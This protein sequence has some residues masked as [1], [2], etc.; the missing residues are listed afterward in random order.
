MNKYIDFLQS[1]S[2]RAY[3]Y[4]TKSIVKTEQQKQLERLVM[5]KEDASQLLNVADI[6][7]G[8]GT[9]TYH[10]KKLYPYSRLFLVDLNPEALL[11]ARAINQDARIHLLRGDCYNLALKDNSF[12]LVCC[13]QTL[14]W[15]DDA[16][17]ALHEMIRVIKPGRRIYLSSLFNI[18]CDVDIYSR[19][20]DHTWEQGGEAV[21]VNYNT[22]SS[23]SISRWLDGLVSSFELIPF[24]PEIDF[25][26]DGRGLGTYTRK[27][28]GGR[29]QVSGGMLLNWAILII[30]K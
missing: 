26:Y 23:Y 9:L 17:E 10:L 24:E 11:I 28:E 21:P 3:D 1:D 15:L 14:S 12:D 4:Y 29:I 5:E 30:E 27:C 16:Q 13:W 20:C 2:K 7:C 8:G 6:A 25:T 19:V 18:E 22:Y